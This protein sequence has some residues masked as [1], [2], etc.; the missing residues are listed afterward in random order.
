M[1]IYYSLI[2][3]L[4]TLF[5]IISCETTLGPNELGGNTD[6]ELTKVGNDFGVSFSMKDQF[7]PGLQQVKDTVIISKN[8]GGIVTFKV[9]MAIDNLY[10]KQI[11]TALGTFKLSQSG[12]TNLID[13]YKAK[14]NAT[15]DTSD[16]RNL[17]TNLEI[18]LK[19]TSD[20]IQ[21]FVHSKGDESKPYTIM[22]YG[23]KIGDKYEFTNNQGE[24]IVRTVTAEHTTEDWSLG[25][26]QVKTMRVEQETPTDPITKKI[27]YIGNHKFGLVGL[28]VEAKDGKVFQVTVLP[29]AVL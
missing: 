11:D 21:D 14:Y 24:K 25:F 23:S 5:L 20:G 29:W 16:K 27:T 12:K 18:K 19:I 2:S 17:R 13:Y 15:I 9:G 1:K 26:L 10:L 4:I 7:I 3:I 22:K 6:I 8:Q 28:I